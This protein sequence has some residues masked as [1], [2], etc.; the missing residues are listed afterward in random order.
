MWDQRNSGIRNMVERGAEV[1]LSLGWPADPPAA[2]GGGAVGAAGAA[3]CAAAAGWPWLVSYKH[4]I[5]TE[6]SY[7]D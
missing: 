5:N 1:P 4:I 6:S 3:A 2:A 7:R